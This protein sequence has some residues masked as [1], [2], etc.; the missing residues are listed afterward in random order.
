MAFIDPRAGLSD[1]LANIPPQVLDTTQVNSAN[2]VQDIIDIPRAGV[3]DRQ[4]LRWRVPLFGW[5]TMFLNPENI[6]TVEGKD[7]TPT[8]TKAGFI[9]QYAGEKLT[10]I[11]LR[12]TTGSAG[13]EG[14]NILRTVYRAEQLAFDR[15][16][17]ELDR[18]GPLAE[19]LQL[20]RGATGT[21]FLGSPLFGAI[22]DRT[23]DIALNILSQPFPTLSSLAANVELF[24][25]G[26]LYRGYFTG[27]TVEEASADQ[28]LFT[29]TLN[30][31]AYARQGI[32]R[33]FMPWHRQ[34]FNPIGAATGKPNPLSYSAAQDTNTNATTDVVEE[35]LDTIERAAD[36]I[37]GNRSTNTASGIN[38]GSLEARDLRL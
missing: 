19:F 12:G 13:M 26:E 11:T 28:G 25:Q 34:P 31:V 5:V 10:E 16:A 9:L 4:M 24:F 18:T 2:N 27:F 21:D 14:I 38:G 8:R 17:D 36:E 33:N 20:S 3:Y 6:T 32:R 7:I 15:I 23:V 22:T 35:F 37:F 1:L 29:Y 30:Y